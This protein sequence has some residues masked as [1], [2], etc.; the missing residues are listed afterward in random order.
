M[1]GRNP[2]FLMEIVDVLGDDPRNLARL[3]E[4]SQRAVAAAGFG[5]A[6]LFLHCKTP[7]PALVPHVLAG[8]EV[9]EVDRLHLGPDPAGRPEVRYPAF[10]GDAGAG[11]GHHHLRL[12]HQ[13]AQPGDTSLKIGRDHLLRV[14]DRRT[15]GTDPSIAKRRMSS[16]TGLRKR[17]AVSSWLVPHR[18]ATTHATAR[19]RGR[20]F[21]AC[22]SPL[23]I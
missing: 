13:L 14:L 15:A 5:P 9:A 2:R 11:E 17:L 6:E 20:G 21:R 16:R 12:L 22:G 7:P 18:V 10:R 1:L 8:Q 19:R 23:A 4:R 3:I